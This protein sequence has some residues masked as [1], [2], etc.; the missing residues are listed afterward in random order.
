MRLGAP[1]A[2]IADRIGVASR[3]AEVT[4]ARLSDLLD[5]VDTD[6]RSVAR[7]A[8]FASA[9]AAG[10]RATAWLLAALPLAG[11]A[12][13]YAIGADPLREL[14]HTRIGAACSTVSVALQMAGLFWTRRL[15]LAAKAI[16]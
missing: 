8:E 16:R 9:Q 5:R 11:I 1:G 6:A 4:G 14:L 15:A 7:I 2:R 3:V 10:V 12:L 13:G